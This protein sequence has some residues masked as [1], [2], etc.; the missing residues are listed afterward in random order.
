M[1]HFD[2]DKDNVRIPHKLKRKALA[3][4]AN[5]EDADRACAYF[6]RT[7]RVPG[8][9]GTKVH[10]DR[11][12]SAKFTLPTHMFHL[13]QGACATVIQNSLKDCPPQAQDI[14]FKTFQNAN[15]NLHY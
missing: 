2:E 1:V 14:R 13:V 5:M 8:L 7:N 11:V 4:F 3:K 9:G 15:M 10:C 12:F 6:Q